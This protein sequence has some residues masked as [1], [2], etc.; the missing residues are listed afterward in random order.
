VTRSHAGSGASACGRRTG[1]ITIS[2]SCAWARGIAEHWRLMP[3]D[4]GAGPPGSLALPLR[5]WG[6]AL[7]PG[8]LGRGDRPRL[9]GHR[10]PLAG[11]CVRS[12]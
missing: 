9:R 6:R 11:T 8:V 10:L 7:G 2:A 5:A 12:L 3:P 1:R 4:A